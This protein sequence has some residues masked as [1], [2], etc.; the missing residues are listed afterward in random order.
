MGQPITEV[1][2]P[3]EAV[4]AQLGAEIGMLS[5]S[6]VQG[7][8]KLD[9]AVQELNRVNEENEGLR[10]RVKA[11]IVDMASLREQVLAKRKK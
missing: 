5:V 11:F 4:V 2:I 1:V 6:L 3:A 9:A 7:R 8:L 10:E